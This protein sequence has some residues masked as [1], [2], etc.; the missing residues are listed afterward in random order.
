M[1][2]NLENEFYC[3]KCAKKG[4]PITRVKGKERKAGHL[5]KIFCLYCNQEV[6]H[7]EC[8]PFSH[9]TKHDFELEKKYGNFDN[10]QNRIMPYGL[11]RDKL[12]KEGVNLDEE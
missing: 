10:E 8:K 1:K 9:Y 11:F 4:F 2:F 12:Y 5:K 3:I 7:V 6:N